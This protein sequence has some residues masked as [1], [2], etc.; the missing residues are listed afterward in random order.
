MISKLDYEWISESGQVPVVLHVL[1]GEPEL[2]KAII[3]ATWTDKRSLKKKDHNL[4]MESVK[5]YL[6]G[7]PATELPVLLEAT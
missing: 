4:L 2:E 7:K 1:D 5:E 3:K 6:A